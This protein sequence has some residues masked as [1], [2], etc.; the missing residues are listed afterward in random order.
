MGNTKISQMKN[1]LFQKLT[2]LYN[3]LGLVLKFRFY[4]KLSTSLRHNYKTTLSSFIFIATPVFISESNNAFQ[5]F[6]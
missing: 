5:F 2:R 6:P 1:Y 3:L 4:S